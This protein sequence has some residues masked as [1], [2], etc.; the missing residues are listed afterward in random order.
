MTTEE[1]YRVIFCLTDGNQFPVG[2]LT[3]TEY[4]TLMGKVNSND[5]F[6][7]TGTVSTN[8]QLL[9]NGTA[10]QRSAIVRY[11]VTENQETVK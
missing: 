6:I 8:G 10:I 9:L 3:L 4:T 11:N 7:F 2:P 5:A 1:R